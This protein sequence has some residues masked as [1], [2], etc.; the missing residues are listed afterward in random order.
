MSLH[1][2]TVLALIIDCPFADVIIG[3]KAYIKGKTNG[4]CLNIDTNSKNDECEQEHRSQ[5][6]IYGQILKQ[7][8]KSASDTV[9]KVQNKS[10][11]MFA[12]KRREDEKQ[13]KEERN[14][15]GDHEEFDVCDRDN[16]Q[17]ESNN[18]D[19]G[20]KIQAEMSTC[21]GQLENIRMLKDLEKCW[22]C[23]CTDKDEKVLQRHM[24]GKCCTVISNAHIF[25]IDPI[26]KQ[27]RLNQ[28]KI[29]ACVTAC[30]IVLSASL[31]S[32]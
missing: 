25:N 17:D 2:N 8:S 30:F 12:E 28:N 4:K 23:K 32:S 31:F 3:E 18:D 7:E 27:Y 1:S 19:D 21:Q 15:A 5:T 13:S 22:W 24:Y 16:D 26:L 10:K 29:K 11:C 20:G 9:S 6:Q 14:D